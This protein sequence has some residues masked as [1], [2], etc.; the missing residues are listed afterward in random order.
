MTSWL[1]RQRKPELVALGERAGLDELGG[2]RKEEL[3]SVLDEYL[4]KN[5]STLSGND[6]FSDYYGRKSPAKRVSGASIAVASDGEVK[7]RR[8]R[9]P[10]VKEETDA[11]EGPSS[12]PPPAAITPAPARLRAPASHTPGTASALVKTFPPSPAVVADAIDVQT[13]RFSASINHSPVLAHAQAVF[14]DTREVL[15]S[16]VCIESVVLLLEGSYL[17]RQI[18]PWRRAFDIPPI[19]ALGTDNYP[20]R[21]PDFFILLTD[22]WWSTTLLW[23]TASFFIPLSASWLFNLTMRPV[24]RN[25]VTI[26]KPRWRCDPLTFNVTKALLAWLVYSQNTRFFGLFSDTTTLAVMRSMPGG[27]PG[28]LIGSFIG[29]LASLYDAAQR[30]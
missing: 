19:Q 9:A 23:L 16:V 1:G 20:V 2:L 26:Q 17:Q 6:A 27:Y 5:A 3:V 13:R 8:K 15:S 11:D 24:V 10:K 28:V 30:K 21:L 7:P 25:G 18:F 12:P 14:N 4:Q 29:T 22:V